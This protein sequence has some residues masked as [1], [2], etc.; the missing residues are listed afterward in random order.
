MPR[1]LRRKL[2]ASFK[3]TSADTSAIAITDR[4]TTCDVDAPSRQ[5]VLLS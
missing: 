1:V 3:M 4:P 5:V 2:Y